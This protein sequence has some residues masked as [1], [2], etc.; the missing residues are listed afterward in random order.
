MNSESNKSCV[1]C[2]NS[3]NETDRQNL[4]L[5][6]GHDFCSSCLISLHESGRHKCP[7]CRADWAQLELSAIAGLK[8]Q[9]CATGREVQEVSK[10]KACLCKSHNLPFVYWYDERK[11]F[12]C[13][14]CVVEEVPV[15]L[16]LIDAAIPLIAADIAEKVDVATEQ[17]KKDVKKLQNVIEEVKEKIANTT[18]FQA[19]LESTK[20]YLENMLSDL[21]STISE[22]SNVTTVTEKLKK[23]C[24]EFKSEADLGIV[25]DAKATLDE[26]IQP[27]VLPLMDESK[28][29]MCNIVSSHAAL[30]LIDSNVPRDP[31]SVA[32]A[33]IDNLLTHDESV[34]R[35]LIEKISKDHRKNLT[36][37][38]V[39]DDKNYL[40][41]LLALAHGTKPT[42]VTLIGHYDRP[43]A[44]PKWVVDAVAKAA[45]GCDVVIRFLDS[46]YKPQLAR[47][48]R[49]E[50]KSFLSEG[51]TPKQFWGHLDAEGI[52]SL[53]T[54]VTIVGLAIN[55]PA[56]ALAVSNLKPRKQLSFLYVAVG[57]CVSAIDLKPLP[58][59]VRKGLHFFGLTDDEIHRVRPAVNALVPNLS[60]CSLC[61]PNC[62]LTAAGL[63]SLAQLLKGVTVVYFCIELPK[64]WN[65]D[66]RKV[67]KSI[68]KPVTNHVLW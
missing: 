68:L 33:L 47:N 31:Q 24:L 59:G 7:N 66:V 64:P 15:K 48:N 20:N 38:W 14:Q 13:N 18:L 25:V 34:L 10:E 62:Q 45:K 23:D 8:C 19:S 44:L 56:E 4:V 41:A 54:S 46:F 53:P 16:V 6:C 3:F 40:L 36:S 65:T 55:S 27:S 2:M 52:S 67:I 39:V 51:C 1:V 9:A 58:G 17:S 26:L 49:K 29:A 11:V 5:H 63:T 37:H 30:S 32:T 60:L 50:L 12:Y 43:H 28:L 42:A 22:R 57:N 35:L 21:E 61:L